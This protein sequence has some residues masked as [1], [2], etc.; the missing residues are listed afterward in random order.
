MISLLVAQFDLLSGFSESFKLFDFDKTKDST[1]GTV[2][3]LDLQL[4]LDRT[5]L[6][7]Y[8]MNHVKHCPV[9]VNCQ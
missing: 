3:G 9:L 5:E 7:L 6:V 8:P 1:F 4:E 2:T